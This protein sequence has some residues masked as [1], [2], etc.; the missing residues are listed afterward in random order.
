MR[1]LYRA[2]LHFIF[3]FTTSY[4]CSTSR[5]FWNHFIKKV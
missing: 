3:K 1:I 2:T 4:D 5:L